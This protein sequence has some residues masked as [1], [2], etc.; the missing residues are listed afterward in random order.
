MDLLGSI[1]NA[2]DK[3]PSVNDKQRLMMKKQREAMLKK[4]NEDKEKL[5]KFREEV[6][7]TIEE[8][9]K[10][11]SKGRHVFEPM[12]HVLRSVVL[13]VV[14]VAGVSA[15]MVGEEGVDRHVVAYKR[16]FA[17][18]EDELAVLRRGE[19]WTPEKAK[20][21]A[22]QRERDRQEAEE[23]SKKRSSRDEK[24]F[25]PASN[26]Y[27]DKYRHLIGEDAALAAAKKT[28]TNRAYGFVPSENKKDVRSI[29]QT[30]ADLQRRKRQKV[31][32]GTRQESPP[33]GN[34]GPMEPSEAA[35]S[36]A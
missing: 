14:E 29:E 19:E 17:P 12:E 4:K 10:D 8:F 36:S 5:K 24:N 25:V 16:E 15:F 18:S 30:L 28:E 34:E 2:M 33:P 35:K 22:E 9:I 23:A 11:D 20:E 27:K 21:I 1:L 6:E 31:D 26:F 3:P 13:D 32:G 7:K